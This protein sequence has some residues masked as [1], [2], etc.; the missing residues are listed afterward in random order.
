M[1]MISAGWYSSAY[2]LCLCSFQFLFGKL[3]KMF[4]F[5]RI[6][7]ISVAVFLVG[8]VLCSA[9]QSS[10]MLVVGRAV[11]GVASSGIVAGAFAFLVKTVPLRRRPL[12]TGIAAG[13]EGISP[14]AAPVIGGFLVEINWRWC[15]IISIPSGGLVFILLAIFLEELPPAEQTTW[16]HRLKELDLIGNLVLVPSLTSL[17]MA[18]SWAG[19]TYAWNSPQVI[20]LFCVFAVLL[21]AFAVDQWIKGD[22]A[23]L[24]PRILK[25]RTVLAGESSPLR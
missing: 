16:K 11:A 25:N 3:Y 9:A 8:S 15:F 2:R 1:D 23:T 24:P 17:F 13:L 10:L 6:F 5:K 4:S 19:S 7:L 22:A 18:L 12:L 14:I 21:G 20:A